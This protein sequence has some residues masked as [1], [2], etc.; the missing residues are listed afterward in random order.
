MRGP[1]R[2]CPRERS[3]ERVSPKGRERTSAEKT[4]ADRAM[5]SI[6]SLCGISLK[7]KPYCH[8]VGTRGRDGSNKGLQSPL[9]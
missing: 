8:A 5:A 6:Q 2:G 1:V 3:G 9:Q 7:L 4:S